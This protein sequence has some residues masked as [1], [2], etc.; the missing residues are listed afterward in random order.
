MT[1]PQQGGTYEQLLAAA[2][3]AEGLGLASFAR[4]DH[5]YSLDT[6]VPAATDAFASLGGLARDTKNIPLCVLVT[7]ITFRHPAV[8]AK[9]AASID[10]MSG[11]RLELGVGTGWMDREHEAYGLPFPSL[12][13]RFER[14]EEAI[15]YLMAAFS[16][17]KASFAGNHYT[18]DADALP[19]PTSMPLIIGGSGS[20][21][22]PRLAGTYADEY[23]HFVTRPEDL[24]PKLARVRKAAADAGRHPETIR[25]S[26]MGPVVVGADQKS[27]RA[28]L[29]RQAAS[30]GM[31]PTAFE[32]RMPDRGVPSG[33]PDRVAESLAALEEAGVTRFYVQHLELWDLEPLRET[34]DVLLSF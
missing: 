16:P 6:P 7:P 28:E 8:I 2:Q 34:F 12:D 14:L 1:E 26:M 5:Y 29:A 19:K 23:N 33:T 24:T 10:E 31:D 9:S 27:Y 11:G 18:F 21:R 17:K 20:Y 32:Q 4:S 3:L 30:Y 13:E 25:V 22:T 15:Q